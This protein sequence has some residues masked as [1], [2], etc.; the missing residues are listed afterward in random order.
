MKKLIWGI[1]F[2]VI[3][4]MNGQTVGT[5]AGVDVFNAIRGGKILGDGSQ[6]ND[7]AID[8]R[9]RF[10]FGT[11]HIEIG[12]F[13]EIFPTID[14]YSHGL[15]V[16]TPSMKLA[17]V[18]F[19]LSKKIRIN[20][21]TKISFG[22]ELANVQRPGVDDHSSETFDPF[23]WPFLNW[24]ANTRIRFDNVKQTNFFI[25]LQFNVTHRNDI[26]EIWGRDALPSGTIPALWDGRSFY[27]N[28]G[29]YFN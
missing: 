27:F 17:T 9:G 13:S 4:S 24:G 22:L 10:F 26:S 19:D 6:R 7:K 29:Y 23:N 3:G 21:D 14:F 15:D 1:I 16:N 12:L 5:T 11:K 25:E 2:L 20:F 28:V 8:Y 18:D